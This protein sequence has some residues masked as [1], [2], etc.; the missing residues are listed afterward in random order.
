L[1]SR[2]FI[3]PK[4]DEVRTLVIVSEIEEALSYGG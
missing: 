3:V 1:V 2:V 4:K